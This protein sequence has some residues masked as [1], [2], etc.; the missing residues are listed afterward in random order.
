MRWR[1]PLLSGLGTLAATRVVLLA[2]Y[3][4]DVLAGWGIGALINKAVGAAFGRAEHSASKNIAAA[5]AL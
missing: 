1:A 5:T 2:H 3:P 4:S